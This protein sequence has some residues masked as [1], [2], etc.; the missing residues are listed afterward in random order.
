MLGC[1]YYDVV[2]QGAQVKCRLK[3]SIRKE[4]LDSFEHDEEQLK[5]ASS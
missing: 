3:D 1:K 4:F 5:V 2:V